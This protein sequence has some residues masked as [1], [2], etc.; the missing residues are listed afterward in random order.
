MFPELYHAHHSRYTED[1]P[2]WLD[3]ATRAG[4]PVLELG[5]GTGRVL[6]QL[7]E[8]GYR[9][10]G[11]DH[12]LAMLRFLRERIGELK[13]LASI[14]A[15]DI[16]RFNLAVKFPLIILP[17]NTFSTL[18]KN[19]RLACLDCTRRH[20]KPGGTFAV[21]VPNPASLARL[22]THSDAVVE[23]EFLHP[24]TGNPVQVSSA[25]RRMKDTVRVTWAYDHLYPDG[26]V[27][28][29]TSET[30]HHVTP[31]NDYLDEIRSA[32]L[33]VVEVFGDFDRSP[34]REDSPY[35]IWVTKF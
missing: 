22:R 15:S 12:D 26:R 29:V 8:A 23:D 18:R 33:K 7:A 9:S 16:T 3:L 20:L 13:P 17:C 6:I 4:D 10:L 19:E 28:R 11:M 21:S 34:Y 5:C 35:L 25:W 14:I 27:E 31:A 32:G 1:L 2:F 24:Q 30:L